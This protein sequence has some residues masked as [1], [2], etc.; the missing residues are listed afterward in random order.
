MRACQV[1]V[2]VFYK[3][4]TEIFQGLAARKVARSNQPNTLI[5]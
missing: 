4:I 3:C 2:Y 1:D 5:T